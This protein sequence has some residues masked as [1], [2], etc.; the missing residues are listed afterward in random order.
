MENFVGFF[1]KRHLVANFL[2][3]FIFIVG[4]ILLSKI[5]KEASPDVSFDTVRVSTTYRGASPEEV[6][7]F[8]TI[9]L[10]D[11]LKSIDGIKKINSNSTF[12][13]SSITLELDPTS[14][15][16]K[17][18]VEE[19][20]N[21]VDTVKLPDD[22]DDKDGP[23]VREFKAALR[24]I[25][26][27]ALFNIEAE[28]LDFKSR[29][30]LQDYALAIENR[31]LT[32][33][34]VNSVTWIGLLDKELQISIDPKKLTDYD[35]SMSS[36]IQVLDDNNI[37]SPAGE[38]IMPNNDTAKV[39]LN[40][41]IRD[42]SE[43]ENIVIQG[44]FEEKSIKIKDIAEVQFGFRRQTNIL[45]INGYQALYCV[46]RKN[47]SFDIVKTVN[48]VKFYVNDFIK[49]NLDNPNVKLIFMDDEST[50]I[51]DRLK[52][53][54]NNGILGFILIITFLFIFLDFKSAFWVSLGIPFSFAFTIILTYLSGYTINNMTLS[55]CIIIMGM[56][57]DDAIVIADNVAQYRAKGYDL[58]T[59]VDKGTANVFLAVL[60]SILTTAVAFVPLYFFSGR[61]ARMTKFIPL[62]VFFMLG[63]SLFESLFILPSHLN[64]HLKFFSFKI[65]NFFAK[66]T[67]KNKK[68]KHLYKKSFDEKE[69]S[70]FKEKK[71]FLKVENFYEKILIF[72]LHRKKYL[73]IFFVFLFIYSFYVVKKD[74]RFVMFPNEES[75]EI[76]LKVIAEP[77]TKKEQM[78][79]M[80]KQVEEVFVED[81][82]VNIVAFMT[83]IAR[84]RRGSD[85]K[86]NEADISIELIALETRKTPLRELMQ[87]WEKKFENITVFQKLEFA[88]ERFGQDSGSAI[89]ILLKEN[90]D[91]IRDK[92]LDFLAEKMSDMPELINVEIDRGLQNAEYKLLLKRDEI[93]KLGVTLSSISRALRVAVDSFKLY[94]FRN[95]SG[96]DI[97]VVV[98]IQDK[99]RQTFDDIMKMSIENEN[100]YLVPITKILDLQKSFAP[101]RIF[102]E[103]YMRGIMVYANIAENVKTTPLEAAKILERDVFPEVYKKFP[104]IDIEFQGEI[105]DSRESTQDFIFATLLVL[106]LIYS[107][108]AITLDST[109][110]PFIIMFA[111]PF[112]VV[113]VILCLKFHNMH[114]YGFFSVIGVLGLAGVVINDSIVMLDK[115]ETDLKKIEYLEADELK[116]KIASIAKTRL[117]AIFLTTATT[118]AGLMPTAYGIAG[119]DSMLSEMMLVMGWGLVFGTFITLF[120]IPSLYYIIETVRFKFYKINEQK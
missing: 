95:R 57:V 43:V 91:E 39:T 44:N 79:E 11:A 54:V 3:I 50:D 83:D 108:L 5:K 87:K 69:E 56:I 99:Y 32:L 2:M 30:S 65:K 18:V 104:T 4:A 46:I 38:Y 117:K 41:E 45:K 40:S 96:E 51:K 78:A 92:A 107:I 24:P 1:S 27:I 22:L 112:G 63:S 77:G 59:S 98:S 82:G 25:I 28:V 6:E 70:T 115:L 73:L 7:Y 89:E 20:R 71:F 116:I 15:N 90:N 105:K 101:S 14:P 16:R 48:K 35:I 84:S 81:I 47:S 61:F 110:K 75:K 42:V 10:E 80:I 21:L 85:V 114:N 23:H 62:V 37:R 60:A 12:G 119:Y 64:L 111:I 76:F 86:E 33:P 8:I 97:D 17:N 113:G 109:T 13:S 102:R 52:L 66:F 9:R 118:V 100:R 93:K 67:F 26:D 58:Q 106:F 53:I 68:S 34:E 29:S 103:N 88:K 31:L 94:D 74:M 36:V 120:L 19:I 55:A 49:N 72:V